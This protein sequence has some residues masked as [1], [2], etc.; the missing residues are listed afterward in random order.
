M[1]YRPE[2][3]IFR[4]DYQPKLSFYEKL[5]KDLKIT[6]K[7]PH[8]QTDR[9]KIILKDFDFNHSL[10]IAHN[11]TVYESDNYNNKKEEEIISLLLNDILNIVD[12]SLFTRFG[13]R[14]FFLIKQNM[15][16]EELVEIIN[17]KFFTDSF[18][19]HFI[20]KIVDSTI[21][22]DTYINDYKVKI[23]MGPMKKVEITRFIKYNIDNHID[24]DPI[25][26][27]AAMDE[28]FNSYPD[29]SFYLDVDYSLY[30][31]NL[32][33]TQIDEF[34]TKYKQDIPP[35]VKGIIIDLFQEKIR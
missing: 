32:K 2:K 8:W 5:Y 34:L 28:L 15:E 1:E 10:T 3:T 27:V 14:R 24:P 35:L 7:F 9:L 18:K 26:R 13:L 21:T 16:F 12:D 31:D 25:K 29:I 11:H 19:K 6:E 33:K 23:T 22:I 4:I 17:L 30:S 20:N